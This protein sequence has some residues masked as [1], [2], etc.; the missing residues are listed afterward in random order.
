[1]NTN[2][3]K[4]VR[5]GVG[6]SGN[7]FVKIRFKDGHLSMTGV[8]GPKYNGDARGGCGQIIMHEWDIST[9]APGFDRDTERKLREVWREWHLNDMTAGSPAQTAYLK[10]HPVEYYDCA[11]RLTKVCEALAAADLNPDP[12]YL[13]KDMPYRY[14]S[15]W[16]RVE[17]PQDVL[18]WL[19]ALPDA[20]TTPAWI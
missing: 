10:A 19:Q 17:V 20:D 15:A 4:I 3:T 6:A 14:G 12:N 8:E 7:V 2:F 5:I 11:D 13:H 1:M 18:D 9:H 16:L